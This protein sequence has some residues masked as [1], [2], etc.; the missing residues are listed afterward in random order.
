MS[1]WM[2]GANSSPGLVFLPW[3]PGGQREGQGRGLQCG[4]SSHSAP[5][6]PFRS[7]PSGRGES[8]GELSSPAGAKTW[9]SQ[10]LG[11]HVGLDSEVG[12]LEILHLPLQSHLG[13]P[14]FSS[15]L[16]EAD[17]HELWMSGSTNEGTL[18][19][20]S[21]DR[22]VAPSSS[23][24]SYGLSVAVFLFRSTK[25]PGSTFLIGSCWLL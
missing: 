8:C 10:A 1:R 3:Q 16:L 14:S 25:V 7:C 15:V 17:L 13:I 2:R 19:G 11:I 5:L 18:P 23:G 12:E 6:G 20:K 4:P 21:E 22:R 24:P 9:H